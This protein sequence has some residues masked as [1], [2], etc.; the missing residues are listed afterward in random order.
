M[1]FQPTNQSSSDRPIIQYTHIDIIYISFLFLYCYICFTGFLYYIIL[2]YTVIT[3]QDY[4]TIIYPYVLPC[5]YNI[6]LTNK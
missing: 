6:I 1:P 4:K 3:G 2:A 5:I